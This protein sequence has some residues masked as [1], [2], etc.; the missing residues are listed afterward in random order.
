[1]SGTFSVENGETLLAIAGGPGETPG[2][3]NGGGGGAGSGVVNSTLGTVLIIAAGGNGAEGN[4]DG[5]GGSASIAGGGGGGAGNGGTGGA[6]GGGGLNSPGGNGAT[7]FGGSQVSLVGI[8]PGGQGN[9]AGA[10]DNDGGSGMGGGGGGGS[11]TNNG[12]GG[13]G[14]HT[15]AAAG[16]GGA[17]SSFNSGMN[18]VNTSGS[19]GGGTGGNISGTITVECLAS[20]PVELLN[21][22]AVI[23]ENSVVD[24]LW[25]TATEKNNHGFDIERSADNRNWKALGFVPGNGT[26]AERHDYKFTDE[27]PLVGVN[28]YRLKQLDFDGKY[29]YS[30]IVVADIRKNGLDFDVFPNPSVSGELSFRVVSQSEGNA[31]L[32]IFDWVGYKVYHENVQL[33]KGTMVYPVSLAT[34]PKGTYT[35]RLQMPD[36]QVYFKKV[37]LQ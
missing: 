13:G 15:G 22:K 14:G 3:N 29:E 20:L 36:G 8:A 5:G 35:A 12:S 37:V 1:M 4:N 32:E 9:G 30:P 2:N 7:G 16:N 31:N 27:T 10:D 25:A 17:A 19:S 23:R 21:F 11:S 33:F 28:Y 34:Y 26:T 6:G 24:L 18:Q